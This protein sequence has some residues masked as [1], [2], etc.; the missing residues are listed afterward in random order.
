MA[1]DYSDTILDTIETFLDGA[2]ALE[3]DSVEDLR[4][5]EH[6]TGEAPTVRMMNVLI[7]GQ[8]Y[9]VVAKRV[10]G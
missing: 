1:R 2:P 9:L 3:E 8:T 4:F 7:D 10:G 5:T 6:L